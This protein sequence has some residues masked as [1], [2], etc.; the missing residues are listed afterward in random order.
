MVLF[1]NEHYADGVQWKCARYVF[2]QHVTAL[3]PDE[4]ACGLSSA[5]SAA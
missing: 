5:A 2:A 1:R 3:V 4:Y